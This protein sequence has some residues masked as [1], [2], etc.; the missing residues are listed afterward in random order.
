MENLQ[1]KAMLAGLFF[2]IWPLLMNRSNL[3]GGMS[4]MAFSGLVFLFIAPFALK[5][6]GDLS[7]VKWGMVI[8]AGVAGAIGVLNFNGMLAKANM[9]NVGTL[10]I[11]MIAV[12][13]ALPAIV[14]IVA[15]RKVALYKGLGVG[16]AIL[17][18]Y[19]LNKK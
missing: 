3:N 13:I 12:Q 17:A 4:S 11:T 2:G 6:I 1:V 5:N 8:L 15:D 14:Q 18:A 19:F 10:F 16:C 7:Q 9:N